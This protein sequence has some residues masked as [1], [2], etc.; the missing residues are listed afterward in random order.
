MASCENLVRVTQLEPSGQHVGRLQLRG[1][2]ETITEIPAHL[3][4]CLPPYASPASEICRTGLLR[5]QVGG[6]GQPRSILLQCCRK[7]QGRPVGKA[8]GEG[9]PSFLALVVFGYMEGRYMRACRY[10]HFAIPEI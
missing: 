10:L 5:A 4:Q 8:I 9:A 6:H 2:L 3:L 1:D 7:E